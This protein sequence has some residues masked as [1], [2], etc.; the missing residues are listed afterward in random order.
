MRK[1][2]MKVIQLKDDL[3]MIEQ[4]F[5]LKM[6]WLPWIS[7]LYLSIVHFVESILGVK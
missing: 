6:P 5:R 3:E 7:R 4:Y 2:G 1:E